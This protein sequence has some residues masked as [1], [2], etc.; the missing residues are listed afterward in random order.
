LVL[1]PNLTEEVGFAHLNE[2]SAIAPAR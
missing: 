1:L 2:F